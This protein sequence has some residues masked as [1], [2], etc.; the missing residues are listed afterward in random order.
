MRKFRNHEVQVKAESSTWI[1]KSPRMMAGL[2]VRGGKANKTDTKVFTEK[3]GCICY[4]GL[5]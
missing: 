2:R 1:L 4:L 3:K 5:L